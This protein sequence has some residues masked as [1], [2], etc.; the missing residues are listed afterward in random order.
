MTCFLVVGI[1]GMIGGLGPVFG[2]MRGRGRGG[3]AGQG[4]GP[5]GVGI[6]NQQYFAR[7]SECP[8]LFLKN[9]LRVVM[10]CG[11]HESHNERYTAIFC[12]RNC[13]G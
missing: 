6:C 10:F 5:G 9:I 2:D 12:C 3:R 11:D 7:F 1:L 13:D 8:S 4:E